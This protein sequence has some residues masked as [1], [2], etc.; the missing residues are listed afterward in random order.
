[1]VSGSSDKGSLSPVTVL[2]AK[3]GLARDKPAELSSMCALTRASVS[4]SQ[5]LFGKA[6]LQWTVAYLE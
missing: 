4:H 6:P 1:M 2:Y 5:S 3:K